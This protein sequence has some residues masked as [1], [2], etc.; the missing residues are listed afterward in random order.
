MD[1]ET[2]DRGMDKGW[3]LEGRGGGMDA[4][5]DGWMDGRIE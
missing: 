5:M 1:A 4:W 3:M 2:C